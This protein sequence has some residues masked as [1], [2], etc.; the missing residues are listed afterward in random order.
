MKTFWILVLSLSFALPV[1][2]VASEAQADERLERLEQ[3]ETI[4][5][6]KKTKK[7]YTIVKALAIIKAPPAKVWPTF[8]RCGDYTKSMLKVAKSKEVS[9]KGSKVRCYIEFEMPLIEN[10]K[11]LTDAVHTVKPGKIYQRKWTMV[12]GDFK[13]NKGQWTLKPHDG[14]ASTLV[15]Y[16]VL[17]EPKIA[18]PT[19]IRQAAQNKLLPDLIEHIRKRVGARK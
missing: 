6:R 15:R 18:V 9:R 17:A 13:V 16:K 8:D 2:M 10:L 5:M 4:I 19:F 11:V 3:G 14:G 1:A 7:G 12:E